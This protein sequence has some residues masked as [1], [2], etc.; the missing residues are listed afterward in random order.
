[1][2]T[3]AKDLGINDF[4]A[5]S[6]WLVRFRK[7]HLLANKR[8]CGETASA[9]VD[10]VEPFITDFWKLVSE[11]GLLPHQ[12]YNSDKTGLFWKALPNNTQ[13][14]TAGKDATGRKLDKGRIS[15]LFGANADGTHRVTL[16][17]V[18]KSRRPRVLKDCMDHLPVH[19]FSS[20]LAF[21]RTCFIRSL[22]LPSLSIRS[23]N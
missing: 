17:V 6:G 13:A 1:M 12:L 22:S 21:S 15:V 9:A 18:G 23:P 8:V 2:E 3:L 10:V 16:V 14:S 5:S 4:R 7:R 11:E 19:Y 20:P